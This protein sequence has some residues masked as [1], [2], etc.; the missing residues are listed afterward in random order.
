M[1]MELPI[2]LPDGWKASRYDI[3]CVLIEAPFGSVTVN[4]VERSFLVGVG[5][6]RR[7]TIGVDSYRG[8]GWRVE[9]FNAAVYELWG[10][11]DK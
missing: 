8:R 3:D 4:V 7:T 9:L 2:D 10:Y 11:A 6:P 5:R 1:V